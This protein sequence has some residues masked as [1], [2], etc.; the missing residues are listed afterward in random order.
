MSGEALNFHNNLNLS[1]NLNLT[2]E[3]PQHP[4]MSARSSPAILHTLYC[5]SSNF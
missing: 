5:A 3:T 4:L 1:L 2:Y